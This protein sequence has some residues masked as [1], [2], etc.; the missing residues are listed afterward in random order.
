MFGRQADGTERPVALA[1]HGRGQSPHSTAAARAAR[2]ADSKAALREGGQEGGCG[3]D[4]MG[5]ERAPGVPARAKQGAEAR[6]W[7]WVEASV[8]TDCMVSA[9]E[10]GVKGDR[11]FSLIDKVYAP[12]TLEAAWEKVW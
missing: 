11:W 7:S 1:R 12:T 4:A 5:Q 10:N 8:W 2:G 9:L 3:K 6:D